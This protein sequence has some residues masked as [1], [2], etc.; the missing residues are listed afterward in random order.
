MEGA[1]QLLAPAYIAASKFILTPS[2]HDIL[3]IV[4]GVRNGVVYGTKIRFPHALV[5]TFLFR[6]GTLK[7][8]FR[9]IFEATKAH[10]T[11]LAKFVFI[12]KTLMLIFKRFSGKLEKPHPFIAGI[13]GGYY[14]FGENNNI[15]NQIVLY[16]F[17]RILVGLA[18]LGVKRGVL[19]APDNTFAVFASLVWGVVMWLF[20][21]ETDTLQASLAA[22]MQ[23]LYNDSNTWDGLRNFLWHNK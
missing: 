2:Y 3:S 7:Q 23:Y 8:K 11:N 9:W 13:I 10:A 1:V 20:V 16:L 22:S 5:M 18:K 4:K 6:S 19:P 12:Y 15:N 21:F 17:S 14:V